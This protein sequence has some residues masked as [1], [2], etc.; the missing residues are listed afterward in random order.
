MKVGRSFVDERFVVTRALLS[1]RRR[2]IKNSFVFARLSDLF[3]FC[4]VVFADRKVWRAR[5]A[6]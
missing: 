3:A 5:E 2:R 1:D 4:R 6:I